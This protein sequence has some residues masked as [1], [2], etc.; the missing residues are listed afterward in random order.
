M[1]V[2]EVI[3]EAIKKVLKALNVEG[4]GFEI[5]HPADESNGD[6]SSNV[7]MKMGLKAEGI[8]EKL[9]GD[10]R[11]MEIVEAIEVAGPG[12]I[13]FSLRKDF[14]TKEALRILKEKETYGKGSWGEDK[15]M[16]IDYSAPNIA[17]QF[18]VGHLRST[19]IGQAIYNLY[20]FS[21]WECVGDN[22][23]G[24]WGTQ[25]G[26]II[27]AV[28]EWN[29]DLS[30]MTVVEMEET[31]V[32]YNKLVKEDETYLKKAQ[33]AFRRLEN[34]E[35]KA[36]KI[37][38]EAVEVGLKD[39]ERIYKLLG[40]KIDEAYGESFYEDKM[41]GVIKEMEEKKVAKT[42]EG[43]ALIVEFDDLP[44]AMLLKSDGS[45]TY[46]TRDMAT[47]KWRLD[48][49]KMKADLYVY[50]VGAEQT[51]HFRQ[52]FAAAKKMGWDG[53]RFVH[54]A[55]GLVLD[56]TGKKMSTRKGTTES[57]EDLLKKMI[58]RAKKINKS[59]SRQV[60]V[61]AVIFNDLKHSPETSYQ[62]SWE[63]ALSMEG[64]S[65]PY[66]QYS[67]VRAKRVID[68]IETS[69][70]SGVLKEWEGLLEK[71]FEELGLKVDELNAEELAVLREVGKFREIVERAAR[72]FSP[73]VLCDY[74]LK[75]SKKF[76]RFY[77]GYKIL[78]QEKVKMGGII[79]LAV[80]QVLENGL[81]LLHIE[82]PQE[83]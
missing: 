78:S 9:K 10:K 63:K 54:V 42:G 67:C 81:K 44:P 59:S 75:L 68:Q 27:A 74:L 33:E 11:L 43:G 32:K 37:W 52:V 4:D 26:M 76:N 19:I 46:F 58:K 53:S 80:A 7:A 56:E 62:F 47:I 64:D 22:H 21:G 38:Q 51:N 71:S 28:E 61:G 57:M 3:R 25:F 83:M 50:E 55:H 39:F 23:L 69:K 30:K 15:R 82:V 49:P 8:V 16:V 12:F 5:E 65:G 35:Q 70:D 60:G 36:R 79:T 73:S 29:L 24:D 45:S 40:V 1:E 34:K 41:K 31:Y 13:N 2:R 18:G 77:G 20:K 66:I 14:L 72:E 6:Y 48:N 17:K